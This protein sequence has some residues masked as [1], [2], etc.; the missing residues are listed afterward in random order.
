MIKGEKIESILDNSF[1][2][3]DFNIRIVKQGLIKGNQNF[4]RNK[5][6]ICGIMQGTPIS[7]TLSNI[8]MISFDKEIN[9][10]VEKSKGLYRRYSDDLV[11]ICPFS[12]YK[13][14]EEIVRGKIKQ[15][16]LEIKKEKTNTTYFLQDKKGFLRGFHDQKKEKGYKNMQYLGFDFDGQRIFIRC[17]SLTRYYRKMKMSIRKAVKMSYGHKSK[18][19]QNDNRVYTTKLK[20]RF[21]N[22]SS[23]SFI[24]YALKSNKTMGSKT[25]HNQLFG[26]FII[27]KNYL[28][29]KIASEIKLNKK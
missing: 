27:M 15:Y 7:A 1:T 28:E 4:N 5:K 12:E 21:L 23:R 8:Y 24:S 11:I 19:K 2:R 18:T 9:D 25:I 26:R 14:L 17:S 16:E 29:K 22:P 13:K 3:K 20:R 10:I 6:V